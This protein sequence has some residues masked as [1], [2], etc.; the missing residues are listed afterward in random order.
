MGYFLVFGIVGLC[1]VIYVVMGIVQL[2]AILA[3]A[4]LSGWPNWAAHL[5]SWIVAFLPVIGSSIAAWA[6]WV[7][8]N[9]T[10]LKAMLVFFWFPVLIFVASQF[11]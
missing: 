11:G 8:W 1:I 2:N 3:W 9:W 4:R 10:L 7:A 5:V 6:A